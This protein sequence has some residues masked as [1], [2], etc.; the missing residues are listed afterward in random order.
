MTPPRPYYLSAVAANSSHDK[1]FSYLNDCSNSIRTCVSCQT[2]LWQ[3][4]RESL[5]P[6]AS[7]NFLPHAKTRTFFFFFRE[8]NNRGQLH[9]SLSNGGFLNPSSMTN[10]TPTRQYIFH[11]FVQVTWR[12]SRT[13][14]LSPQPPVK[15]SLWISTNSVSWLK[16]SLLIK[17]KRNSVSGLSWMSFSCVHQD[18]I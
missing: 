1:A 3:A 14:R 10:L 7:T 9:F 17:Q 5:C 12:C 15:L 11:T 8:R 18:E 13:N 2:V 6:M 4:T 16:L